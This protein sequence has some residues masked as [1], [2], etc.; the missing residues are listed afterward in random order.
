MTAIS[1]T[2]NTVHRI[3]V[4]FSAQHTGVLSY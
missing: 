3:Y 2:L 1:C 4:E